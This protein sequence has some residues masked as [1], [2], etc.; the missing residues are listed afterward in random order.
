MCKAE[1]IVIGCLPSTLPGKTRP[2]DAFMESRD[3]GRTVGAPME[4]EVDLRSP[5]LTLAENLKLLIGGTVVAA[6]V[7]FAATSFLPARFIRAIEDMLPE[8]LVRLSVKSRHEPADDR[9]EHPQ[10]T[11]TA[12]LRARTGGGGG[13]R[14]PPSPAAS[15]RASR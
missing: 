15:P 2:K 5:V 14:S 11:R 3:S 10:P 7:A 13:D 9:T 12:R 1:R 8:D 4:P 6:V